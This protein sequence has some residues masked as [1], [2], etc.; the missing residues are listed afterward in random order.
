MAQHTMLER[1]VRMVPVVKKIPVAKLLLVGEIALMA[2]SHFERLEP[3]ERRRF[4]ALMGRAHGRTRNLSSRDREEFAALTAKL[5]P[6]LFAGLVAD[7]FSPVP[8]PRRVIEGKRPP[9]RR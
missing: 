8:L 4:L 6:R 9:R 7:R 5:A 1:S 3:A 2:R